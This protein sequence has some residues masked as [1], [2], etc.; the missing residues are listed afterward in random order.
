[1]RQKLIGRLGT[2]IACVLTIAG[3]T[4][5]QSSACTLPESLQKVVTSRYP[6][7]TLVSLADLSESDRVLFQKGHEG[8]CPGIVKVDFYGDGKPT[9]ALVLIAGTGSKE[10]AELVV[11]HEVSQKWEITLLDEAKS[12]IPVA[13]SQGPGKYQD[14]YGEKTI[15]AKRPVIIFCGYNAWAILYSWTGTGLEK[16]WLRD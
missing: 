1:M 5:A 3:T 4:V 10:K 13:W 6:G 15:R 12:S 2:M 16:I 14:L 8:D 11:A 7:A 9:L